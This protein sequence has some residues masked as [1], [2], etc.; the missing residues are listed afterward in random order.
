ML[1]VLGLIP[2]IIYVLLLLLYST[3]FI[4]GG[5]TV[6]LIIYPI[7]IVLF[8]RYKDFRYVLGPAVLFISAL[9]T[10]N[11]IAYCL[12]TI[13]TRL[14]AIILA[15]ML[16]VPVSWIMV[17]YLII[18]YIKVP[19]HIKHSNKNYKS[20]YLYFTIVVVATMFIGLILML[21]LL[22][23][24][25]NVLLATEIFWG[26]LIFSGL[27]ILYESSVIRDEIV[28]YLFPIDKRCE[29]NSKRLI[30]F[31][32][33]GLITICGVGLYLE[34]LRGLWLVCVESL[35]IFIIVS[36][37]IYKYTKFIFN[38]APVSVFEPNM[39]YIASIRNI[40]SI[41]VAVASIVV[42][43]GLALLMIKP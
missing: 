43:V 1:I 14:N 27:V 26:N 35:L 38:N 21:M 6:F 42:Y 37:L 33:T 7:F 36:L 18:I 31:V 28:E 29:I 5:G 13:M 2:W 19:T 25:I 23:K 24:N 41:F 15:V 9:I 16:S 20:L 39:E 34:A 8:A 11:H 40:R 3:P 22:D 12:I 30:L 17:G 10:Y 32:I 4:L